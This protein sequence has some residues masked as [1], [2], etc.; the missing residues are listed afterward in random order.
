MSTYKIPTKLQSIK[1]GSQFIVSCRVV[2]IDKV[3]CVR[4]YVWFT[5]SS[6]VLT[7]IIEYY[8]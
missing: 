4:T 7:T 6:V 2:Y 5:V 8:R 3:R 1:M